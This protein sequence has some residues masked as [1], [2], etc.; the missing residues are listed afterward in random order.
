VGELKYRHKKLEEHSFEPGTEL[1]T[2][3]PKIIE[4]FGASK[5]HKFMLGQILAN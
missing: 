5:S 1:D 3:N 4:Y 2:E